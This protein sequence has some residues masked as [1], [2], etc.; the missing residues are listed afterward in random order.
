MTDMITIHKNH[1]TIK[2]EFSYRLKSK[3]QWGQR[4]L[5]RNK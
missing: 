5:V 2:C 1:W 4:L 3:A